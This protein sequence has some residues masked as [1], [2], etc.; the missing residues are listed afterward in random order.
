MNFRPP[1]PGQTLPETTTPDPVAVYGVRRQLTPLSLNLQRRE[2]PVIAEFCVVSLE[3]V[4][5]LAGNVC[6]GCLCFDVV[7]TC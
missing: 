6:H 3:H 5:K 2:K 4:R 7:G 1:I